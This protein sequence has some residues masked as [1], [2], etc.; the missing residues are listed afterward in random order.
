M[1]LTVFIL[2]QKGPSSMHHFC[3]CFK[4]L[5][6]FIKKHHNKTEVDV[7][8][9]KLNVHEKVLNIAQSAFLG[10]KR[11]IVMVN[12]RLTKLEVLKVC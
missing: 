7:H 12:G 6:G 5:V 1:L 9:H 2:N 10:P 3:H 8:G 11:D 4:K